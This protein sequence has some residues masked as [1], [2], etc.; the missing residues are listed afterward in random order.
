MDDLGRLEAFVGM[1]V[2]G[3]VVM[4]VD[5]ASTRWR[6]G[7]RMDLS[8]SSPLGGLSRID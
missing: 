8:M 7:S 2:G 1:E 3:K 4:G 6:G 5:I